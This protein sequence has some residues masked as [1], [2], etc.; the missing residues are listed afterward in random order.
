ILTSRFQ[1]FP[2]FDSRNIELAVQ[3]EHSIPI[4]ITHN[5][6]K[7]YAKALL[8]NAKGLYITNITTPIGLYVDIADN[9]VE[10]DSAI[11]LS[12]G[13]EEY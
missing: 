11:I 13:L 5:F 6:A 9:E 7:K 3:L 1:L 4:E 2:D 10:V 12:G 8:D